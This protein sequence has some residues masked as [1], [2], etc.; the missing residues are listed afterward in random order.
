MLAELDWPPVYFISPEQFLHVE[1]VS[2]KGSY[3]I[4]SVRYPVFTI[5]KG[6]RGKAKL[7]TIYHEILHV[8]FPHWKHWRIECCAERLAGGGGRG[9]WSARYGKTVDD[10]PSRARILELARSASQRMKR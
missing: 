3:G 4:S 6:L 1:G 7:N 8:M 10:V 9:Y 5:Q 2:V